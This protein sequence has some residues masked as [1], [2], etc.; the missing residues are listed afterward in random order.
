[1]P[2]YADVCQAALALRP[3]GGAGAGGAGEVGGV[4]GGLTLWSG[5]VTLPVMTGVPLGLYKYVIGGGRG[6]GLSRLGG[7][8]GGRERAEEWVWETR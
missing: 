2:T 1:M 5:G 3:V 7:V 4:G 6:G 8:E